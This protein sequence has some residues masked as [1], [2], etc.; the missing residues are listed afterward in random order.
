MREA[1]HDQNEIFLVNARPYYGD[2]ITPG[3]TG[4]HPFQPE[5]PAALN[6]MAKV[7]LAY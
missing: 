6:A 3:Q 4:P 2:R 7:V 5:P 1:V